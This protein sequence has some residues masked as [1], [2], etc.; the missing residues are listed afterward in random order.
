MNDWWTEEDAAKFDERKN[1]LAAQYD[2]YEVIDG[3]TVNGQFT[4]GENIGDLGGLSIAYLAYKMS[5]DGKE[6]PVIDGWTGEQR[7]FL[8]WA[9]VWRIKARDAETKRLLTIDSHAPGRFRA[10][11]APVN[12]PAFYEAFDVKKATVCISRRKTG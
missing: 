4:S 2:G 9:Q 8:G 7:L 11:G 12:I 6:S 10:I 5:L 1:A 3:L